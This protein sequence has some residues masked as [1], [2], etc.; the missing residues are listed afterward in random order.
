MRDVTPEG[1]S[2][3]PAR[4]RAYAQARRHSRRVR[5][6]KMAIPLGA[7][8]GIGFVLVVTFLDPFNRMAGV[9]L[10]PIS[11]NGTKITMESPR[12]SGYRSDNRGYEVTATVAVQDIR[13]PNVVEL[14]DMKA[15]FA[16]DAS[17]KTTR[18]VADTG[19]FDTTKEQL[20]LRRNVR[21]TTE[22]GQE[23]RLETASI[24][25]KAGTV[26]SRERVAV[27]LPNGLVEADGL[28]VLDSGKVISFIGRVSTSF[29]PR[30]EKAPSAVAA[31]PELSPSLSPV[32]AA[33]APVP[34][35]T[36]QAEP[37][38]LAR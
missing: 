24:D 17:G 34:A 22:D 1:R 27:K 15:R 38:R 28:E 6:L 8:L 21:V 36:S 30:E 13:K 2:A 18:L 7:F 5:F 23:A 31:A 4:S 11:L 26:I 33:P 32:E 14:S 20:E 12:L 19:V 10:G 37:T 3:N 25:F 16:T 9:T 29:E 35:R